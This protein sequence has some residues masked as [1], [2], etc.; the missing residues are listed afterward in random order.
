MSTPSRGTADRLFVGLQHLL[1]QHALSR[2]MHALA[3][4]RARPVKDL[5]IR[6][7]MS[8]YPINL[9]EAEH[10]DP[11]AYESFN[12]FFTRALK[13]GARTVD[14][15]PTAVACPV[16]GAIS[17][18]GEIRGDRL[19]QAKG[20][21]YSAATLLGGDEDLAREF[22]GGSFATVYLAPF[23]YH[24]IHMPLAGT[25]RRA[26]YVGGDLFSV[27][28]ATAAGVPG[29]FA[30]NERIACVFDTAAGPMAVVLVGALF[31]GSM[32]LAWAGEVTAERTRQLRDLPVTDP[33]VALDK[34]AELGRFNMGSTVI[35]MFARDRVRLEPGLLPG[36]SV[37]MGD[38]IATVGP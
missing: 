13:P 7:F 24:R 12:A 23:N 5:F 37:Q 28:A 4:V 8:Q 35:L 26:R 32:S 9:A 38:R 18:A 6:V 30:R 27:N 36:S 10:S 31:V 20:I 3:R 22:E 29:L 15:S 34:G 25:L 16:D 21:D 11:A 33:I 1:P 19:L 14:P 17:Q 2:G